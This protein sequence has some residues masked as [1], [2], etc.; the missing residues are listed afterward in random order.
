MLSAARR[1]CPSAAGLCLQLLVGPH[2]LTS[3]LVSLSRGSF[4]FLSWGPC[5]LA[6]CVGPHMLAGCCLSH[7]CARCT[8][9]ICWASGCGLPPSAGKAGTRGLGTV[10]S[11]SWILS[12]PPLTTSFRVCASVCSSAK[13]G[14]NSCPRS[15]A[16]GQIQ[17]EPGQAS[18]RGPVNIALGVTSPGHPDKG[19]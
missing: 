3:S 10:V 4:L 14:W 13:W 17:T 16:V 8:R 5:C 12:L 18:T 11:R 1:A 2:E 9:I 7:H 6:S 15:Q 19:Q